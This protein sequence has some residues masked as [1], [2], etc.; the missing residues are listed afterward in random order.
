MSLAYASATP[1]PRKPFCSA[2]GP[3]GK[4]LQ[5]SRALNRQKMQKDAYAK[6]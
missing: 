6:I 2:G 3:A 5:L 4:V 1:V